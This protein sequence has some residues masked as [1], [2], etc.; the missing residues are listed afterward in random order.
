MRLGGQLA[1]MAF[2]VSRLEQDSEV[3]A[4]LDEFLG[5]ANMEAKYLCELVRKINE[6]V[7]GGVLSLP[8][9]PVPLTELFD[10]EARALMDRFRRCEAVEISIGSLP[11]SARAVCA[12]EAF[13]RVLENLIDNAVRAKASRIVIEVNNREKTVEVLFRD[14]GVGMTEDQIGELGIGPTSCNPGERGGRGFAYVRRLIAD[15][16]G[17]VERPRSIPGFAT[18]FPIILQKDQT[19][20]FSSGSRTNL[21]YDDEDFCEIVL[22]AL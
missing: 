18:E 5:K 16:G 17:V 11:E 2:Q 4:A 13:A 3:R 14:N 20:R 15:A 12:P 19:L 1:R 9:F 22:D 6:T 8:R 10:G 7:V 21:E